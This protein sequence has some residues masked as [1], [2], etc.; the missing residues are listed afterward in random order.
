[1]RRGCGGRLGRDERRGGSETC[2]YRNF[3]RCRE[4]QSC[5]LL[6]ANRERAGLT[7][8]RAGAE[9]EEPQPTANNRGVTR[10]LRSWIRGGLLLLR[11]VRLRSNARGRLRSRSRLL[12]LRGGLRGGQ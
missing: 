3:R 7:A 12:C 8:W 5:D 4:K 6:Q 2:P 1:M 11:R 10:G 9:E